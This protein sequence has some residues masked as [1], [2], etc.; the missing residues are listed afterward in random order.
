MS[1][2]FQSAVWPRHAAGIDRF[3]NNL[4][5]LPPLERVGEGKE[6]D[7]AAIMRRAPTTCNFNR[8][9]LGRATIALIATAS[10]RSLI[11]PSTAAAAAAGSN[12][13]PTRDGRMA[14]S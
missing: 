10:T 9:P 13:G 11:A 7:E 3:E 8:L 6:V 12:G 14:R 4:L 1:N 2:L 5:L